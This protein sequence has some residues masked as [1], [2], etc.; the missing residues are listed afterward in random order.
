M[1]CSLEVRCPLLDKDLGAFA[2]TLPDALLWRPPHGTK[3]ILKELASEYLPREWIDRRKVGFGLPP[4]SWSQQALLAL[5]EDAL[6]PD[7]A[8]REHLDS[9]ALDRFVEDQRDPRLFSIYRLWPM[10]ILEFWLRDRAG[11]PRAA[12]SAG[13]GT[14]HL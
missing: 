4:R 14:I 12:A 2:A 7:A 13:S 11:R 6:G 9:E 5:A 3:W 10:L 8:L 1:Q